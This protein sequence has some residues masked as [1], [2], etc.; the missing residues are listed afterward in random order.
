MSPLAQEFYHPPA[1]QVARALLGARLVRRLDGKR[2]SGYI[3]ETEAYQGEEDL[4][5][6]ARAG[7]TPRTKVMYGPGGRAYIYL[8][9]GMYWMLNCVTGL[10]GNPQAVLIRAIC[11]QEGLEELARHRSGQPSRVWVD[12]PGK[13]CRAMEIDYRFNDTDLTDPDNE[14]VIEP[15]QMVPDEEI[16]TGPRIGLKNVPEPWRSLAWRFR[17]KR[18]AAIWSPG[19]MTSGME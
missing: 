4:A 6:H 7:R 15:G 5:C 2:L 18:E 19:N 11:P 3:M 14:L 10:E 1:P 12:G 9:Y 13:I 16:L 17:V 8:I